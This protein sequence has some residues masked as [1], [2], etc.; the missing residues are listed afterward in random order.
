LKSPT[1]TKNLV[2]LA[3]LCFALALVLSSTVAPAVSY[4]FLVDSN[5]WKNN[6]PCHWS[7]SIT[8]YNSADANESAEV[9]IAVG[10]WMSVNANFALTKASSPSTAQI[11]FESTHNGSNSWA[12]LTQTKYSTC[13]SG[14]ISGKVIVELNDDNIYAYSAGFT[15]TEAT[16]A[17]EM[18]HALGLGHENSAAAQNWD[19]MYWSDDPYYNNNVIGP[20]RDDISGIISLYGE[21]VNHVLNSASK[22]NANVYLPG[23][24]INDVV[25]T[26]AQGYALAYD[27]STTTLP[28]SNTLILPEI[29]TGETL[30]RSAVGVWASS[31]PTDQTKRIAIAEADSDGV[32]LVWSAV[33][34]G[35]WVTYINTITATVNPNHLYFIEI[36]IQNEN[37]SP[38]A[39]V[40]AYD[41]NTDSWLG[42]SSASIY[43]SWSTTGVYIGFAT[44]TD[45]TSNPSSDYWLNTPATIGYSSGKT[46]PSGNYVSSGFLYGTNGPG[47]YVSTAGCPCNPTYDFFGYNSY[48]GTDN[49]TV[50]ASGNVKVSGY[51][52]KSDTFYSS[53]FGSLSKLYLYVLN[54]TSGAIL[55]GPYQIMDGT[56]NNNQWYHIT[57]T[58]TGLTHGQTVKIGFGRTNHWSTDWQLQAAASNVLVY[59][60]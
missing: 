48:A 36:A 27:A 47:W 28:G 46:S 8:Y 16:A 1:S 41:Y 29:V 25:N 4:T 13:S 50:P 51:F 34:M 20:T 18:G 52:M 42:H 57:Y 26:G 24:G 37:G 59:P 35:I 15:Q 43:Y 39:N 58:I 6:V 7:S 19:L 44:W 3:A 53:G 56:Y 21:S 40:W 2:R 54:P 10:E 55:G 31:N 60:G 9:T 14:S 45:S 5:Y 30:Y 17:H 32:K 49:M 33:Y 23:G 11:L 38:T 12:G 22:N